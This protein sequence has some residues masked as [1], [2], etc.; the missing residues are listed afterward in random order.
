MKIVKY[1]KVN[2]EAF[3]LRKNQL[4]HF[5]IVYNRIE[6]LKSLTYGSMDIYP[7]QHVVI[8]KSVKYNTQFN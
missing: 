7:T 8:N 5:N 1:R 3:K 4:L 6:R 2:Q